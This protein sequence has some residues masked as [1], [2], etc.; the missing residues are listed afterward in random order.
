MVKVCGFEN[1]H[2]RCVRLELIM[3]LTVII[4]ASRALTLC[5]LVNRYKNFGEIYCLHLQGRGA[6]R[7]TGIDALHLLLENSPVQGH[8]FILV[9]S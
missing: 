1:Q 3:V 9:H 7:K 2:I 8:W 6:C 5:G 4:M